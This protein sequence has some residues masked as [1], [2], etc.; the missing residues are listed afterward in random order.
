MKIYYLWY[1][2]EK[3]G[4]PIIASCTRDY[5]KAE[6]VAVQLEFQLVVLDQQPL[7][8]M[9]ITRTLINKVVLDLLDIESTWII[10]KKENWFLDN[11][12]L[13]DE[14]SSNLL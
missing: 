13:V 10:Y 6:E 7:Y 5:D 1:T 11:K 4:K 14:V 2:T 9:G 8:R 3:D 12:E